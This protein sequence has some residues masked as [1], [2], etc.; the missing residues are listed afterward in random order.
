[1]QGTKGA[2]IVEKLA[3]AF[4]PWKNKM[5]VAR[6]VRLNG[7]TLC[8]SVEGGSLCDGGDLA[9]LNRLGTPTSSS[10]PPSR[11]TSPKRPIPPSR[12]RRTPGQDRLN[13]AR[14]CSTS[15]AKVLPSS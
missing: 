1:V 6:K 7:V 12:P 4:E 11:D 5:K 8:L 14:W 9:D 3:D 10:T 2:E 13:R 15:G